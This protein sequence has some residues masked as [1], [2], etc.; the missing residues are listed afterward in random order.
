MTR[1]L[2]A[3]FTFAIFFSVLGL[4]G[5]A[6]AQN[7]YFAWKLGATDVEMENIVGDGSFTAYTPT[8]TE[9]SGSV[10]AFSIAYGHRFAQ[11][12][13]RLEVEL[14]LRGSVSY[15]ADPVYTTTPPVDDPGYITSDINSH[16][17]F[18]NLY[19]DLLPNF[20]VVPYV[21]GGV[22]IA[23]NVWE[24]DT[25]NTWWWD[26]TTTTTG[27]AW[28]VGGGI[29]FQLNRKLM[30]DLSYRYIDLGEAESEYLKIE[31]ITAN[32]YRLGLRL[33]F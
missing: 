17:L 33:V 1:Q 22:G 25:L 15:D 8:V 9:E 28:N 24:Y 30:L 29:A 6:Q 14:T 23:W 4:A 10:T 5:T 31:D 2:V 20:P 7:N 26:D 11:G 32:E 16:T 21:G 18:A 13:M 19:L 3:S 27:V 12:F